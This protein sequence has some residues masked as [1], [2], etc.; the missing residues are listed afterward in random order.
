MTLV[1]GEEDGEELEDD[2]PLGKE[3]AIWEF[4]RDLV[5]SVL[6]DVAVVRSLLTYDM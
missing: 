5:T 6:S 4:A 1:D 2:V 3:S